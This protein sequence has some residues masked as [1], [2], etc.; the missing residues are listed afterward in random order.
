[1]AL[2]RLSF[3]IGLVTTVGWLVYLGWVTRH[4]G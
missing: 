3:L 4:H 2:L 1:M